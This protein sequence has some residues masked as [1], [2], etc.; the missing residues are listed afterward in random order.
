M[1]FWWA[2]IILCAGWVA[3]TYV[4]Y[5]VILMLLA[6]VSPRQTQ[7]GDFS[8]PLSVI[9]AVHNGEAALQKKLEA[10][11]ALEYAGS[12]EIIVA[13]DGSTDGTHEIAEAFAE[14]GVRRVQL[15]SREG[16]E[17]AQAAAIA[18]AT[19][20]I[21]VF[22]DLTAELDPGALAAVVRPFSDA[23]VGSVSSEDRVDSKGGEGAYVR[24]EMAL[25][26]LENQSSTLVGLSGSL[27]AIRRELGTPWPHD[28][29][30]DFRSALETARRGLRAVSEPTAMARFRASD[31][32]AQEWPRKVRTVRRGLA[33][34][35]SYRDLLH[36]RFGRAAFSL[37]GHKVARFTSP[38]A[39]LLMLV[40]SAAAAPVSPAAQALL[41][42]QLAAYLLGGLA[43]LI[44]SVATWTP[45]R[46]GGFFIL[47][48]ASILVA[49]GYH[50]S[51]RRA[52]VWEPTRR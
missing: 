33:V 45:A 4:G 14:R 34:L 49:W 37:W 42:I 15:D 28:L 22:T 25:R 40:A 13:S 9:I 21:L 17:S 41:V 30:S 36:P 44:P 6:R 51:G 27:F 47:V 7:V 32:A 1:I 2:L 48:N 12:V 20:D 38:F 5:P 43:L 16:K 26:R 19:G 46:L 11:L 24:F 31:D 10:T 3:F 23:A 18:V 50:L 39:L 8:P 52:V 29:A 35:S